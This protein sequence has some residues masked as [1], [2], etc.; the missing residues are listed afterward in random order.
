MSYEKI[1]FGKLAVIDQLVSST[2]MQVAGSSTAGTLTHTLNP[3]AG[4][5]Y[6]DNMAYWIENI[7]NNAVVNVTVHGQILGCSF[8]IARRAVASAVSGCTT[9]PKLT[10]CPGS[11]RPYSVELQVSSGTSVTQAN[12][13]AMGKANLGQ[14]AGQGH[15]MD[16][17][18]EWPVL[19]VGNSKLTGAGT[20]GFEYTLSDYTVGITADK[21]LV[22]TAGTSLLTGLSAQFSFGPMKKMAMWD[23]CEY[24]ANLTGCSGT[25]LVSIQSVIQGITVVTSS[26]S[27]GALATTTVGTTKL[28][29]TN[30]FN[31]P[32]PSPKQI[33]VD[34][35]GGGVS[36]QFVGTIYAVAKAT[37]GNRS[38]V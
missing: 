20:N 5:K 31:G 22:L 24:Y 34:N 30:Q 9:I 3:F 7:G 10:T 29:F 35:V 23:N 25:W 32:Q 21:T 19:I 16:R 11:I 8:P 1:S 37:R 4:H 17:V 38:K 26:L 28:P 6:W 36:A 15:G 27:T 2:T 33:F 14:A 12:V 13:Y 18:V